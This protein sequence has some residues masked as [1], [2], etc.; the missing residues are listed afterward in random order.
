MVVRGI[1][2]RLVID[3][4]GKR[5]LNRKERAAIEFLKRQDAKLDNPNIDRDEVFFAQTAEHMRLYFGDS[6]PLYQLIKGFDYDQKRHWQPRQFFSNCIESIEEN[7][8]YR[9]ERPNVI[10]HFDNA[11]LIG[12]GF[13]ILVGTFSLGTESPKAVR[14]LFTHEQEGTEKIPDIPRD[15]DRGRN[16]ITHIQDS[17]EAGGQNK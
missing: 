4:T 9:S 2:L 16:H 3:K 17:T 13:L 11:R 8:L 14:R 15:V 1:K 10:S 5:I 12:L 6:S 7:G